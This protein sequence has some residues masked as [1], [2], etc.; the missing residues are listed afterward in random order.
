MKK[1]I[2]AILIVFTFTQM[3]SQKLDTIA[4][5]LT[6]EEFDKLKLDYAEMSKSALCRKHQSLRKDYFNK[7]P[8]VV[9]WVDE[10]EEKFKKAITENLTKS[11]FKTVKEAVSFR[12]EYYKT[13]EKLQR[14]YSEVFKLLRRASTP[15]KLKVINSN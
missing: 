2:F 12:K 13:E 10:N 8:I 15:Q 11:K 6:A 7:V 5:S 9:T 1:I 3:Y 4:S 14:K